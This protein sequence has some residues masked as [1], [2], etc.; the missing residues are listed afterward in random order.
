MIF[1]QAF[2]SVLFER[3]IGYGFEGSGIEFRWGRYF[4]QSSSLALRPTQLPI[5]WT[6]GLFILGKAAEAWHQA[7]TIS[8][9]EVKERVELYLFSLS[10]PSRLFLGKL[11]VH[12]LKGGDVI[13]LAVNENFKHTNETSLIMCS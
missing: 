13:Y 8:I 6:M 9:A 2:I 5:Q 12:Y 11:H 7:P 10:G 1:Y 3:A 4:R